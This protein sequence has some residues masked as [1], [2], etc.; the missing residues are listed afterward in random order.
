MLSEMKESLVR[1]TSNVEILLEL[2]K[3]NSA[4]I[5]ELG[6]AF[7][8]ALQQQDKNLREELRQHENRIE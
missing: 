4:E 3:A 8:E 7:V 5:T 6:K 1:L 2:Q